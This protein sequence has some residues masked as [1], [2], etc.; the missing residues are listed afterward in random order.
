MLK[1]Q[2]RFQGEGHRGSRPKEILQHHLQSVG[3]VRECEVRPSSAVAGVVAWG[4]W[5]SRLRLTYSEGERVAVP[6]PVRKQ[7]S[8]MVKRGCMRDAVQPRNVG[9][10]RRMDRDEVVGC[11][12]LGASG[13][14]VG[15]VS[16]RLFGLLLPFLPLDGVERE[17]SLRSRWS[18]LSSPVPRLSFSR[19]VISRSWKVVGRQAAAT[20]VAHPPVLGARGLVWGY[21][22]MYPQV[23]DK[24]VPGNFPLDDIQSP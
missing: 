10:R 20:A 22:Y 18:F 5:A 12:G 24:R 4:S 16:A 1:A 21:I 15:G 2:Q 13:V 14:G 3:P 6:T 11:S 8:F 9:G 23:G 19:N 7:R 17:V